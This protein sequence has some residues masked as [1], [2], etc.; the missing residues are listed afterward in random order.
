MLHRRVQVGVDLRLRQALD[1][2][3]RAVGPAKGFRA[4]SVRSRPRE[5]V[6]RDRDVAGRRELVDHPAHPV[7]EAEDLVDQHHRGRLAL[8]LW[9]SEEAADLAVA[10]LE[11]DPF[12]VARRL[13]KAGLGPVLSGGGSG[14]EG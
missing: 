3:P 12:E 10:V 11:G 6:R 4:A 2:R 13:L 1:L 9:E 5:E 7:G 8:R 14:G